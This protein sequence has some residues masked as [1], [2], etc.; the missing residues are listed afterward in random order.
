MRKVKTK[1]L[2][3]KKSYIQKQILREIDVEILIFTDR[4]MCSV[5]HS[6]TWNGK[7]TTFLKNLDNFIQTTAR[8]LA[9]ICGK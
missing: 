8:F 9:V 7:R 5:Q 2:G 4:E 3:Q 6:A 1:I